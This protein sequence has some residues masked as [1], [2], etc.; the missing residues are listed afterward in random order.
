MLLAAESF[1]ARAQIVLGKVGVNFVTGFHTS[2]GELEAR[3]AHT[4]R[5]NCRLNGATCSVSKRHPC[6]TERLQ[7]TPEALTPSCPCQSP[8]TADS[9]NSVCLLWWDWPIRRSATAKA[10][11]GLPRFVGPLLLRGAVPLSSSREATCRLHPRNAHELCTAV[12]WTGQHGE[13]AHV[14]AT[15][16]KAG[17]IGLSCCLRVS[18]SALV[19]LGWQSLPFHHHATHCAGSLFL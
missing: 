2:G 9:S 16:T 6:R 14:T 7:D 8:V 10:C 5:S 18:A 17:C 12:A 15:S 19:Q 4:A 3:I 1:R 11:F 13:L